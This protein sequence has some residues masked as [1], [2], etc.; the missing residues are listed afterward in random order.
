[1]DLDNDGIPD[2]L[3]NGRHFFWVL[4][5]NGDG[6]FTYANDTWG[7]PDGATS[8]VDEGLCFGDVDGD[9]MLDLVTCAKGAEA[10]EKGV[11]LYRNALPRL[12]GINVRLIGAKG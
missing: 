12:H 8:A 10:K 3:I 5:G 9:G 1:T 4:R 11:A 6:T 2:I 7:L